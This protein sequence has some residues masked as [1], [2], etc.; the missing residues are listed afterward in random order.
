MSPDTTTRQSLSPAGL[1][2]R[3]IERRAVEVAIWGIPVV[4]IDA[5]RQGFLRDMQARFNDIVYYRLLPDWRFQTT[6]AMSGSA[7]CA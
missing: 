2:R 5:I 7:S 1:E 6:N 3:T 4:A